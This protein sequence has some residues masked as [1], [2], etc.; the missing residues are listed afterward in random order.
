MPH[1]GNKRKRKIDSPKE[2]DTAEIVDGLDRRVKM[3]LPQPTLCSPNRGSLSRSNP[4]YENKSLSWTL[5]NRVVTQNSSPS[6]QKTGGLQT[7]PSCLKKL[8]TSDYRL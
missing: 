2:N 4:R 8:K 5:E 3:Q 7:Q 1:C 6:K